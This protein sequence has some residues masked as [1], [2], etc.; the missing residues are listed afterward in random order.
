MQLVFG[1][2][3]AVVA[4]IAVVVVVVFV[5]GGSDNDPEVTAGS[6]AIPAQQTSDIKEAAKAAGCTL[7]EDLAN[8]GSG[9]EEK[10]FKPSDYKQ[11]PPTSGNRSRTPTRTEV[12]AACQG[13]V[14]TINGQ[15]Y[16][17][18]ATVLDTLSATTGCDTVVTYQLSFA[19]LPTRTETLELLPGETVVIGGISY[20]APDTVLTTL[21]STTGGCDTLVTYLLQAQFG[22]PCDVKTVGCLKFGLLGITL[23]IQGNKI[24]THR[25]TNFCAAKMTYLA[26]QLP[27]GLNALAPPNGSTYTAPSGR[28]YTVRNPNHSPFHSIRFKSQGAGIGGGQ[29]DVFSYKLP[30]Q[31]DPTFIHAFVRLDNGQGYEVHLNNYDCDPQSSSISVK[32]AQ[33]TAD[34]GKASSASRQPGR[35]K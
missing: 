9:H 16:T 24:Y 35:P 2:G 1:G 19:P 18:A 8:E 32:P 3:L 34:P 15:S 30:E 21:P 28:G 20:S 29:S 17:A 22:V 27:N 5:A 23:D 13:D 31:A 10:E 4:V 12:I 25:V 14:V 33:A 11:N 6:A 7:K 26:Y